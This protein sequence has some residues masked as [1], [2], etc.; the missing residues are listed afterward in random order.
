MDTPLPPNCTLPCCS[1]G[2]QSVDDNVHVVCCSSR[3]NYLKIFFLLLLYAC[4]WTRFQNNRGSLESKMTSQRETVSFNIVT[5]NPFF[6]RGKKKK[7]QVEV[8][9]LCGHH[10]H[11]WKIGAETEIHCIQSP[12]KCVYWSMETTNKT[13]QSTEEC[14]IDWCKKFRIYN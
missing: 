13:I 7:Q 12:A 6:S 10:Y 4:S 2:I 3:S 8:E 1:T 9:E 11:A 5:I 14:R